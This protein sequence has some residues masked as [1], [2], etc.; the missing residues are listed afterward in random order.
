MTAITLRRPRF[1]T[2]RTGLGLAGIAAMALA[3]SGFIASQLVGDDTPGV[4]VGFYEGLFGVAFVVALNVALHG[5]QRATR[6]GLLWVVGAGLSFAVA[7]AALYT[8]LERI[9]LSVAA[10]ITGAEPLT[11]FLFVLLLLRGQ[12]HITRRALAGAV[13]V[14]IGV[15][16]VGVSA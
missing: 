10:P 1:S 12:E 14:V 15:A 8:A 3:S 13:L 5:R 7:L 16:V 4:V 9:S 6:V 2:A 11:T